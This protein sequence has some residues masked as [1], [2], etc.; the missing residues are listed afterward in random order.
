[1]PEHEKLN[2]T[3]WGIAQSCIPEARSSNEYEK[4]WAEHKS[5]LAK[6]EATL[7]EAQIRMLRD[8]EE[9]HIHSIALEDDLVYRKI[10]FYGLAKGIEIDRRNK[11]ERTERAASF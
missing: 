7:T 8:V 4:A 2:D 6:L 1:M 9:S 3:L 10:F 11:D 5:A